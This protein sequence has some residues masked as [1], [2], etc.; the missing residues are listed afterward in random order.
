MILVQ[1]VK[2]S[3]NYKNLQC[4]WENPL[5]T[6]LVISNTLSEVNKKYI[7]KQYINSVEAEYWKVY[8]CI[9]IIF[10][11]KTIEPVLCDIGVEWI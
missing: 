1:T 9:I 11:E 4:I 3:F 8:N 2:E 7:K 5:V 10:I 6:S